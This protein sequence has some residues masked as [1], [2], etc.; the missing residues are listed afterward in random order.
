[1][2][3]KYVQGTTAFGDTRTSRKTRGPGDSPP[4]R[5]P[6]GSAAVDPAHGPMEV[7]RTA[8]RT[9]GQTTNLPIALSLLHSSKDQ[10]IELIRMF[11]GRYSYEKT[12]V[13]TTP[14]WIAPDNAVAKLQGMDHI[15]DALHLHVF[16]LT[17]LLDMLPYTRFMFTAAQKSAIIMKCYV[18]VIVLRWVMTSNSDCSSIRGVT[19]IDYK[20]DDMWYVLYLI[21]SYK[22][23][24]GP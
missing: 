23:L 8:D 6:S 9:N 3:E 12:S 15:K 21:E 2:K 10:L 18:E 4:N 16:R 11:W 1:M 20:V 24:S 5:S 13:S 7:A 19:G 17:H 14:K 22:I